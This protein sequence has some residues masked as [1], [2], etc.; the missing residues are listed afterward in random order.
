MRPMDLGAQPI[1]QAVESAE[2][3]QFDGA[4]C[5]ASIARLMRSAGS[6]MVS[7]AS[8][9]VLVTRSSAASP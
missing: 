1:H 2:R 7:A 9:T 8:T 3:R 5:N 4:A 6:L